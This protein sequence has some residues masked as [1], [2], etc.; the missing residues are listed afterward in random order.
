MLKLFLT[1]KK[2]TFPSKWVITIVY[3]YGKT[4]FSENNWGEKP[5][6]WKNIPIEWKEKVDQRL[7]WLCM[8]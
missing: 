2:C 7:G 8:L 4:S 6:S 3:R 1:I 5:L